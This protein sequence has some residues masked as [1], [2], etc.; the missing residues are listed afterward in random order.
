MKCEYCDNHIPAGVTT[1][2]ACGAPTPVIPQ[3]AAPSNAAYVQPPQQVIINNSPMGAPTPMFTSSSAP[4]V[5][6]IV[7]KSRAAY[8]V[9]GILLGALGIH[10]FYAGYAG[11]GATQLL[12]TLLSAGVFAIVSALWALVEICVV[13]QDSRGVPF[14]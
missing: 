5:V 2:P 1:C 7:P 10:N 8:V 14:S 6:N 12:I 3:P 11:R 13:T 4:C 9:L